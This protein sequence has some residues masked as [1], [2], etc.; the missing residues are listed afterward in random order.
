MSQ[1]VTV[2]NSMLHKVRQG[3]TRYEL[4]QKLLECH[5]RVRTP[6]RTRHMLLFL[7]SPCAVRQ[8]RP[9]CSETT[10]SDLFP[11]SPMRCSK[12]S[13]SSICSS[14]G[15]FEFRTL[16][17]LGQAGGVPKWTR[18]AYDSIARWTCFWPRMGLA[19]RL[20]HR[21]K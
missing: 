11:I 14:S 17:A 15:P 2:C 4:R 3:V 16:W 12:G 20:E 7:G 5:A 10:Y 8:A 18:F 9:L 21:A 13:V 1:C 6:A 19:Y